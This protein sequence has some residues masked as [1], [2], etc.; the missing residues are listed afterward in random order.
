MDRLDNSQKLSAQGIQM[1]K[2]FFLVFAL[3]LVSC[4]YQRISS[5]PTPVASDTPGT[6]PCYFNW[7]TQ[8]LPDLTSRVQAAMQAAGL[9][10]IHARVEAYGENCYD[11]LTNQAVSFATLETDFSVTVDVTDLKN[12]ELLG[13]TLERIL[14]VLDDFPT[15]TVPGPQPGYIGVVFQKGNED[16]R[17][18]FLVTQ[19]REARDNGLHG[20]GLLDQLQ[21]R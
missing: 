17:L 21:T 11:A 13:N 19:G 6:Q 15:G 9:T 20:A 2:F 5:T 7:A 3:V 4:N 1:R 16:L 10:G 8:P 12:M 14:V 18:W